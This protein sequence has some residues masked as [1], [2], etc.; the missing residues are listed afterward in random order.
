MAPKPVL[1]G[2]EPR[3]PFWFFG[4]GVCAPCPLG[5]NK[6]TYYAAY[7]SPDGEKMSEIIVKFKSAPKSANT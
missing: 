4:Q 1:G 7:A 5:S 6:R 2:A 3:P